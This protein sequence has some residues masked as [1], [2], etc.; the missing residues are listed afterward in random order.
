[1]IVRTSYQYFKGL[2]C[3]EVALSDLPNDYGWITGC[4]GDGWYWNF[5]MNDSDIKLPMSD[6]DNAKAIMCKVKRLT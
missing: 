1:V 6:V 2:G 4:S 5:F 3:K